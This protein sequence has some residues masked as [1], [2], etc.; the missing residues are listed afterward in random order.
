MSITLGNKEAERLEKRIAGLEAAL[1]GANKALAISAEQ[2]KKDN[3]R[4]RELEAALK[5]IIQY[6]EV[7]SEGCDEGDYDEEDRGRDGM[8]NAIVDAKALIQE[9]K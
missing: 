4:A 2:G 3:W 9:A 1:E 6:Q 7:C 5:K 8:W